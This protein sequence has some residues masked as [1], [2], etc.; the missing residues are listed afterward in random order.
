MTSYQ[1]KTQIEHELQRILPQQIEEC[2]SC[3]ELPQSLEALIKHNFQATFVCYDKRSRTIEV[4]IEQEEEVDAYPDITVHKFKLD[5]VI[6]QIKNTFKK[7]D[8]DLKFYGKLL[9]GYGSTN[10]IDEVVLV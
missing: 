5:E 2:R 3:D 6:S 7:A 10:Q 8:Q 9:A 1:S 4:G